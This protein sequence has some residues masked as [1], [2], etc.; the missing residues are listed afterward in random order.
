MSFLCCII[1]FQ[2]INPICHEIPHFDHHLIPSQNNL[3]TVDARAAITTFYNDLPKAQA[4]YWTSQLLPQSIGVY[5][6]R[7]TY[8]AW[9]YI[10]S[11]YVLCGNDRAMSMPYAEIVLHA[12]RTSGPNMIDRV[13]KCESAGHFVMLSQTEWFVSVLFGFCSH[14][15]SS[16]KTV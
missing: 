5:W 2:P 13:E 8:A 9:R 1:H 11:T 15:I 3:L 14:F 12:A 6:S 16:R 10:P 7:T 4:D